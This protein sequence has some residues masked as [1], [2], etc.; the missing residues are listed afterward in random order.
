[1]RIMLL[2]ALSLCLSGISYAQDP[3]TFASI[4]KLLN[5]AEGKKIMDFVG[6][7]EKIGKQK[8]T[9]SAISIEK[10]GQGK[11]SSTWIF[12]YSNINW[13]GF[14]WYLWD[15]NSNDKVKRLRIE[16]KNPVSYSMH[17]KDEAGEMRTTNSIDLYFLAKDYDEMERLFENSTR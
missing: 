15:E 12:D 9:V 7:D 10:V 2:L 16:F 4:Q 6:N 13:S 11:Y 8:Y 5:K 1:M 17:T 3:E 14:N